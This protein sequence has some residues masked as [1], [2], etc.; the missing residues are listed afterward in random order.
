MS[1]VCI[2]LDKSLI[3]RGVSCQMM[4]C[5]WLVVK[6]IDK[7]SLKYSTVHTYIHILTHITYTHIQ[8][9]ASELEKSSKFLKA[10]HVHVT[11][12]NH[13]CKPSVRASI[14]SRSKVML[15]VDDKDTVQSYCL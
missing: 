8:F 12:H 14:K 7:A 2:H 13:V 15:Y 10:R 1:Y 4:T 11:R 9:T 3:S 6:L 5:L